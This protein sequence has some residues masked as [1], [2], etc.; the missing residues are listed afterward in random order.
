MATAPKKPQDRRPKKPQSSATP[1]T[2]TVEIAGA[3]FELSRDALL[4]WEMQKA[5]AAAQSGLP[6]SIT[7]VVALLFGEQ[8]DALIEALADGAPVETVSV[9]AVIG[10]VKIATDALAAAEPDSGN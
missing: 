8:E 10:A 2:T 9:E 6:G 3:E 7:R 5:L 1:G 4:S